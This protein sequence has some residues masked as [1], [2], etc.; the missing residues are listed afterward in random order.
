MTQGDI[1]LGDA[2][3]A[4]V[5][6]QNLLQYSYWFAP[7][8]SDL[9]SIINGTMVGLAGLWAIFNYVWYLPL[10]WNRWLNII[11]GVLFIVTTIGRVAFVPLLELRMWWLVCLA[12]CLI[13]FTKMRFWEIVFGVPYALIIDPLTRILTHPIAVYMLAVLLIGGTFGWAKWTGWSLRTHGVTGSDPY[14]YAQMGVDLVTN[15]TVYHAFPL[16]RVTH[17]L[18][19]DAPMVN[20]YPVT[21]IGYRLPTDARRI[22][23]TVWAPGYAVFTGLAY[24]ILGEEGL[25]VVT[26]FLALLSLLVVGLLAYWLISIFAYGRWTLALRE[27]NIGE[28]TPLPQRE[29]RLADPVVLLSV[30]IAIFITASSY[31]Q[32]EWQ[33]TPMA[34]IA[35]QLFSL[36]ALLLAFRSHDLAIKEQ[37]ESRMRFRRVPQYKLPSLWL[38]GLSGLALGIAFDIRYTQ[39]LIAIALAVALWNRATQQPTLLRVGVCAVAAF[40]AVLPVFVYHTFAFGSPFQTGS[41]ELSNFSISRMPET[42]MRFASEMNSTREFGYLWL[43]MLLGAVVL[44]WRK[45][46]QFGAVALY[47]LPL[48]VFHLFYDYL[49]PRDLL[50]IFPIGAILA[51][52]GFATLYSL[53][54]D[55]TKLIAI[56]LA[57]ILLYARSSQTLSLPVTRAFNAFGY[58]VAEQRMSFDNI[59]AITPENAVIGGSLNSGAID[60]HAKRLAFRPATWSASELISF[61]RALQGEKRPV[62]LLNDGDEVKVSLAT[63]QANFRLTEIGRF[64]M[65]YYF[66]GGGSE[67]RKVILYRVE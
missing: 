66:F 35:A 20:S 12:L 41:E 30:G 67:N 59:R 48:L 6:I 15:G 27:P 11:A 44:A 62:F 31:Q 10:P 24:A 52:L 42:L 53:K 36:L 21:H 23:P 4:V 9:P 25:Y 7:P 39:V 51:A 19:I 58:L 64:D 33:M 28:N 13:S 32:V 57:C 50:S 5:N 55:V 1:I 40:I 16:V 18:S 65:P 34:D 43:P 54:W 3:A 45:P 29:Y 56:V 26:P 22:S 37:K 14:A 2:V 63:L 47:V 38:A 17:D 60:L 61:V 49:R 46:Q 8:T